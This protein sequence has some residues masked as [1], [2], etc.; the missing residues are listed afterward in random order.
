MNRFLKFMLATGV[1]IVGIAVLDAVG[2]GGAIRNGI[3]SLFSGFRKT[4]GV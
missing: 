4:T 2:I 3:G 1:T